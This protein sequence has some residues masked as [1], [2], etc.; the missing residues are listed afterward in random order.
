MDRFRYGERVRVVDRAHY[1]Y[2]REGTVIQ[3]RDVDGC[4]RVRFDR[5]LPLERQL[6]L[7]TVRFRDQ[8]L[9]F[10]AHCDRVRR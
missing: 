6:V 8:A 10:P 4:A 5:D 2:G 9:V 1:L 3:V 7:D